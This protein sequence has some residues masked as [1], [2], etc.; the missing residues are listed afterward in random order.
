MENER[1]KGEE[2]DSTAMHAAKKLL[3][4]TIYLK[5]ACI[6]ILTDVHACLEI[7]S[8]FS[9]AVEIGL[10][11]WLQKPSLSRCRSETGIC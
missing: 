3:T 10:H 7:R 5:Y 6:Y 2:K 1:V 8:S 4:L 11:G 9:A